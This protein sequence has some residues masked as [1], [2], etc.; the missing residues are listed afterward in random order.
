[1]APGGH[2]QQ[3]TV[4]D[5]DDIEFVDADDFYNL[6]KQQSDALDSLRSEMA[7]MR[8]HQSKLNEHQQDLSQ[9]FTR[10]GVAQQYSINFV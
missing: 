7:A 5:E 8:D 10:H 1:M 2:P 6:I 3:H 4:E 9:S